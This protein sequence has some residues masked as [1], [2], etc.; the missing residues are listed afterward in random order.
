V[1]GVGEVRR[2]PSGLLILPFCER[3]VDK[4]SVIHREWSESSASDDNWSVYVRC[5]LEI[6]KVDYRDGAATRDAVSR[7]THSLTLA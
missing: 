6:V 2:I 4:A 5:L 7:R 1:G 3:P